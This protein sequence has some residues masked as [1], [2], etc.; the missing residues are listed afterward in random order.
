MIKLD[1]LYIS[2]CQ[3]IP[4]KHQNRQLIVLLPLQPKADT[5]QLIPL[6]LHCFQNYSYVHYPDA[7]SARQHTKCVLIQS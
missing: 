5:V 7:V 3:Q 1:I 4:G 6:R 2:Y